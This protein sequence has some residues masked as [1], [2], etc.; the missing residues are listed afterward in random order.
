MLSAQV[1][2]SPQEPYELKHIEQFVCYAS[3]VKDVS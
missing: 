1:P 3:H 2:I